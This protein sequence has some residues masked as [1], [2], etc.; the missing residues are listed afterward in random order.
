MG[1]PFVLNVCTIISIFHILIEFHIYTTVDYEEIEV[2]ER[3]QGQDYILIKDFSF[4]H[5]TTPLMVA[6]AFGR[7][8]LVELLI[9]WEASVNDVGTYM[10][11]N[12]TCD[13]GMFINSLEIC[14]DALIFNVSV[15]FVH[16]NDLWRIRFS[17]DH[18]CIDH[19]GRTPL[20]LASIGDYTPVLRVLCTHGASLHVDGHGKSRGTKF[21]V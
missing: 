9:S 17:C 5:N 13:A 6:S 1:K 21:I 3:A 16:K 19:R 7:L 20:M 18:I 14:I 2:R 11:H 4:Y 8:E 12:I 15:A 10:T